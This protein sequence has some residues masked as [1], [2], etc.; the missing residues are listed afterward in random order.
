MRELVYYVHQYS[1]LDMSAMREQHTTISIPLLPSLNHHC[2]LSTR[3]RAHAV[4]THLGRGCGGPP[5]PTTSLGPPTS[6]QPSQQRPPQHERRPDRRV[7]LERREEPSRHMPA[8][9]HEREETPRPHADMRGGG[10]KTWISSG[11][12]WQGGLRVSHPPARSRPGSRR[13]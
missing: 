11:R 8:C 7:L 5:L 10:G 6:P 4:T 12:P 2:M 3:D 9:G 1:N 13:F